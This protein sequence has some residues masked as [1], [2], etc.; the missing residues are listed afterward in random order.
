MDTLADMMH[1]I[2]HYSI[3]NVSGSE[4]RVSNLALAV[5]MTFVGVKY[6]R[7]FVAYL[8]KYMH[9]HMQHDKDAANAI[10]KILSYLVIVVYIISVLEIANIP[11]SSFAFVGGALALGIG[12]GGQN[13]MNNFIS[14]LIIMIERPIK[15]GDIVEINDMT[16]KI[17]S[18][19]ARCVSLTSF[20]N[21]EVLV[22]NSQVMQNVLVNWTFDNHII[23]N[24]AILHVSKTAKLP[25]PHKMIHIL[26]EMLKNI[27]EIYKDPAPVVY[28]RSV[29]ANDY[30]YQLSF[31]CDLKEVNMAEAMH[32]K[33]NLALLEILDAK[34]FKVEYE[35]LA[36]KNKSDEKNRKDDG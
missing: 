4:V 32:S 17:N 30:I 20:S 26:F 19:G 9:N 16:G 28:V 21:V 12:L 33:V 3:L 35:K 36:P 25:K 5:I 29:D 18:I 13:L 6:F 1:K 7:S 10:E 31:S 22:P 34:D 14:S 23:C 2:W 11:L 27:P 8:R 15:I 24:S